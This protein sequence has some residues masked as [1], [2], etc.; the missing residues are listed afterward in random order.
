MGAQVLIATCE[1]MPGLGPDDQHLLR[2][3]ERRGHTAQIAVWGDPQVAWHEADAVLIRSCWD[4]YLRLDDFLS[5]IAQIERAGAHLFNSPEQLRWNSDKRYL[6]DL[7]LRGV[8]II[9]TR[10]VPRHGALD[11]AAMGAADGVAQVVIKPCVS[12]N[13]YET[14][15]LD[16]SDPASQAALDALLTRADVLIQ[17]FMEQVTSQG[18][19]SL[20]CIDG[21]FSHAA[22]KR[23]GAGDFRVQEI[24]G[25]VMQ[26]A[27]PPASLIAQ[28]ERA[29]NATPGGAPLYARVDGVVEGEQLL[30]M[31][32]EIIEPELF[33]RVDDPGASARLVIALEARLQAKNL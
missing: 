7:E 13:A 22:L 18:E 14:R 29:A 24:W 1:A 9:P 10:R 30:L 19:W 2:A 31:E 16:P 28:A 26:A 25:G 33:F 15:R 17:P 8:P 5:W 3:L 12:A 20:V 21:V 6:L 23:P 11:L 27:R 4:Y 32:L